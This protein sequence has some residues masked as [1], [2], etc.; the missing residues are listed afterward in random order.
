MEK[1][2]CSEIESAKA[3]LVGGMISSLTINRM[4]CNLYKLIMQNV[5]IIIRGRFGEFQPV[6]NDIRQENEISLDYSYIE[7]INGLPKLQISS[8]PL[9]NNTCIIKQLA[10]DNHEFCIVLISLKKTASK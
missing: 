2:C 6:D 8:N 3:A 1:K 4:Y 7:I 10:M 5:N 9:I